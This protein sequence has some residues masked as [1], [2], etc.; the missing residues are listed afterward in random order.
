MRLQPQH[1]IRSVRRRRFRSDGDLCRALAFAHSRDVVHRDLKP[2]NVW[3]T[4]NG[5][6]KLGDFGIALS[7]G[8]TRLTMP[9]GV[10]GTPL[11]MAPE[12]A[13]GGEIDA[14]TDLYALGVLLYELVAG[15]PPFTGD[16]PNAII[17]QHVNNSPESLTRS[18]A[19]V[20]T[21]L[22]RLIMKLLSKEKGERYSSADDVL[23]ELERSVTA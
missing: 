11:Y 19:A 18:N 8:R 20:P 15:R 23:V 21:E 3:L 5:D 9:G 6:A 13:S 7:A 10:S 22:E 17:Y 4:Q 1:V 2:E 14:R 16:D 12:Q